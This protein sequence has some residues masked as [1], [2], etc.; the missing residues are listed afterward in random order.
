MPGDARQ[1]WWIIQEIACRLGLDWSY[2]GP[3]DIHA[4]M[5]KC[6]PSMEHISWDRLEK[7]DAVT[8]PCEDAQTPGQDIIFSNGFPTASGRGKL[9]PADILS[10]DEIP[11]AEYPLVLTTGRVLEHWHTGA[12]TRRA[13]HLNN[14]EPEATV[15]ISPD[16]MRKYGLNPGET[17]EISTRRGA[18][19]LAARLEPSMPDGVIFMPFCYTEA[20]ANFL[21]NPVLD[22]HAKIPEL[23]FS[24][25]TSESC[26]LERDLTNI[27]GTGQDLMKEYY[28][29]EA[30]LSV[31]SR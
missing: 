15:H 11:D 1:D 14:I 7:E 13:A 2:S 27:S 12:M 22:P 23:K 19:Q 18:V 17:V 5:Q 30:D 29:M 21:T 9:V 10:S 20:A 8:Y 31:I 16:D 25:I 26:L 28:H 6:M 3:E 24:R 4:E